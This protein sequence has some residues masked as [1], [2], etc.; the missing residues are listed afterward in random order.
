MKIGDSSTTNSR[1]SW[2]NVSAPCMRSKVDT[3]HHKLLNKPVRWKE[4][5]KP[6]TTVN[7]F[8]YFEISSC[9]ETLD[10]QS[11]VKSKPHFILLLPNLEKQKVFILIEQTEFRLESSKT[12]DFITI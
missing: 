2:Q 5:P 6:M 11:W 9:E 3:K 8:F 1:R 4:N 10:S 12:E 7:F